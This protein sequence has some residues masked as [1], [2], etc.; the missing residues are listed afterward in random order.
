MYARN[1][2]LFLKHLSDVI[3]KLFGSYCSILSDVITKV[4]GSYC[5]ILSDLSVVVTNLLVTRFPYLCGHIGYMHIGL[6]SPHMWCFLLTT[7]IVNPLNV[8]GA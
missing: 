7:H 1:C 4:F 2:V 5:S 6:N 3:T 8:F